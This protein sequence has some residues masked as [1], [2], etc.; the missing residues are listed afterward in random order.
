M[1]ALVGVRCR[2]IVVVCLSSRVLV[3]LLRCVVGALSVLLGRHVLL[4]GVVLVVGIATVASSAAVRVTTIA[5]TSIATS[6][7]T[8]VGADTAAAIARIAL[9]NSVCLTMVAGCT[10][11]CVTICL[12]LR[13]ASVVTCFISPQVRVASFNI[14]Y[15]CPAM[16]LGTTAKRSTLEL[17]LNCL[18]LFSPLNLYVLRCHVRRVLS[19]CAHNPSVY[20][21]C[22]I[23]P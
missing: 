7:A 4:V 8:V 14:Y 16:V 10:L 20:S 5:T 2:P 23:I 11:C 13:S 21:R 12:P 3:L 22:I 6:I 19:P 15:Q 1:L 18:P 9:L 17:Q